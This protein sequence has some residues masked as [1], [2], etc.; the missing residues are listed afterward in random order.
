[1]TAIAQ[2][3]SNQRLK[4]ALIICITVLIATGT[5]A[6]VK[7][8]SGGYP[9]HQINALR[10][11]VTLPLAFAYM[12]HQGALAGFIPRQLGFVLFR[13]F[14]LAMGNL[15]FLL[16]IATLPL[17]DAAAIYFTMPFFVAGIAAPLLGER[18][19]AH[20]WAAIA[21]GFLGVVITMRPGA[22]VFEPAA[23]LALAS[24]FFYGVGQ[25]MARALTGVPPSVTAF[26]QAMMYF[27]VA[28]VLAA[29]FGSGTFAGDTQGSLGFLTRGWMWPEPRDMAIM[30]GLG[31]VAAA[32][33][34]LF[35]N[36]YRMADVS[37]VAPFEYTALLW[38]ALWGYVMFNEVPDLYTLVG[39]SIVIAA[40]IFMLRMDHKFRA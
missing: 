29:V 12:L 32:L 38:S 39:A 1:M 18:V 6:F 26:W 13:G 17:A 2:P 23:L 9:I 3:I 27:S 22:G 31:A 16:S 19:R 5:D 21:A 20:R 28:L 7:L 35:V 36:A 10:S 24:A 11:L 33:M 30:A 8:L 15:C 25:S 40:G 4:G 14:L 37:F 34:A